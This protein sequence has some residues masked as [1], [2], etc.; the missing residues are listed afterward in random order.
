VV[1]WSDD[2]TPVAAFGA[3]LRA[4]EG[5]RFGFGSYGVRV[6]HRMARREDDNRLRILP[7]H[8]AMEGFLGLYFG[9]P[10]IA[11]TEY[12]Q[13]AIRHGLDP[14][15]ERSIRARRIRGLEDAL[16]VFEIHDKQ[17]GVALFVSDA[18]ASVFVVPHPDDYRV[19]HATLLEDFYGELLYQ[20]AIH[21]E[22]RRMEASIDE[23]AV[24]S[25]GDLRSGLD[26]MKR[27]LAT[28]HEEMTR[29]IFGWRGRSEAVY[30]AGPFQLRRFVTELN[31]S[32]ENH[33]GEVIVRSDD[34]AIEYMKSYRLSAAQTRRAFL[35]SK[36]AAHHWNLDVTAAALG[37]TKEELIRRLDNAGFGYLIK[38]DI[39]KAARKKR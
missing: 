9:G 20:Y 26:R 32:E 15:F 35:L 18:L 23:K 5:K 1:S 30:S 36:L 22:E 14:R 11:W 27:A 31:P 8:L 28:F 38:E 4:R 6:A 7:L 17:V 29:G 10:E 21:A 2:G 33:I 25:L 37:Q 19:L 24:A 13:Q 34:G 12:S 3:E 39:L 16:R